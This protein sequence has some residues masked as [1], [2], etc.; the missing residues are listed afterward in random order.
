MHGDFVRFRA[1]EQITLAQAFSIRG[2]AYPHRAG[3]AECKSKRLMGTT[4][5]TCELLR[6]GDGYFVDDNLRLPAVGDGNRRRR[7]RK[8]QT[9]LAKIQRNGNRAKA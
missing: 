9:Y 2:K 1:D 6:I 5:G 8:M 3:G 7:G 4:V